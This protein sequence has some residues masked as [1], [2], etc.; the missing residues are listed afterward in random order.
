MK[1]N[2]ITSCALGALILASLARRRPCPKRR[3][4]RPLLVHHPRRRW[5]QRRCRYERQ[6]PI[7]TH[8]N[9]RPAGCW[10]RHAQGWAIQPN[11]RLLEFPQRGANSG[12]AIARD[13]TGWGKRG[14]LVAAEYVGIL[15]A[16][17]TLSECAGLDFGLLNR[18]S[19]PDRAHRHRSRDRTNEMFPAQTFVSA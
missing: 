6:Q 14:P 16:G 10:P 1:L 8:W 17:N 2:S 12:R 3:T 18:S 19:I 15:P 4:V 7:H 5:H 13:Q 11:R 9:A